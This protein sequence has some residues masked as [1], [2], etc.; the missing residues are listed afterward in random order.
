M[1]P[2]TGD[3]L[4]DLRPQGPSAAHQAEQNKRAR[5]RRFRSGN[6]ALVCTRIHLIQGGRCAVGWMPA[7]HCIDRPERARHGPKPNPCPMSTRAPRPV[8][9]CHPT[10]GRDHQLSAAGPGCPPQRP[11]KKLDEGGLQRSVAPRHLPEQ[12]IGLAGLVPISNEK[13]AT[14]RVAMHQT[15]PISMIAQIQRAGNTGPTTACPL[16]LSQPPRTLSNVVDRCSGPQKP[17]RSVSPLC[18][19]G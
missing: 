16:A 14:M 12:A 7:P 19:Y 6:E 2:E 18:Q 15:L 5:N 1:A 11:V 4:L 3:F 9:R 17:D 8:S 10:L 13:R